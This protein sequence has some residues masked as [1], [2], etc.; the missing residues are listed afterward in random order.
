MIHHYFLSSPHLLTFSL[1]FFY[2]EFQSQKY[3][4][5]GKDRIGSV[6]KKAL[7]FQ[8]TDHTFRT[9]IKKPSWLGYLGPILQAETGDRIHVHVKNFASRQYSFHPHGLSY[10][11][12]N[13]GKWALFPPLLSVA[14]TGTSPVLQEK[15]RDPEWGAALRTQSRLGRRQT[16][17]FVS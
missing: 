5:R 15:Q 11:K 13:E 9:M 10:T 1:L 8:Y 16:P 12:S 3:L 6:Y 4:Q 17:T 14:Y 7:Y 2:R